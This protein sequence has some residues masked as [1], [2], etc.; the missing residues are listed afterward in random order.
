MIFGSA[1]VYVFYR[2]DFTDPN[3][4]SST[5]SSDC[6]CYMTGSLCANEFDT[7][8]CCGGG[9]YP[10]ASNGT[11]NSTAGRVSYLFS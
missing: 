7:E 11:Y 8:G 4:C 5:L 6:L 1:A 9:F 10:F 2:S 3:I